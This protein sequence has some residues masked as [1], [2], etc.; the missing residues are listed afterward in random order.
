MKTKKKQ[1]RK[2]TSMKKK[3]GARGL[4]LNIMYKKDN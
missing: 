1:I 3:V 2:N 4:V